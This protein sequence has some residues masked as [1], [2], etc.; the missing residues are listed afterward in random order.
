MLPYQKGLSLDVV[1]V[2]N[3]TNKIT[4]ITLVI[5]CGWISIFGELENSYF[6]LIYLKIRF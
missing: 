4:L 6:F 2:V 1:V 5:F 3:K